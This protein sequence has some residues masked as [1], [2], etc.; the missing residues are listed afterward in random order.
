MSYLSI[1]DLPPPPQGKVGWPWTED[2]LKLAGRSLQ[3]EHWPRISI[4]TPNYNYTHFIEQTIRSILLQGYP[5]LEYI[6]VDDGSTDGS[7]EIIK[8]YEKWL[9][10][11]NTGPNRGQ[12]QAS[13]EGFKLASGEIVNWLCSD[14]FLLPQALL[15]VG[16][17]FYRYPKIDCLVGV[18]RTRYLNR[19]HKEWIFKPRPIHLIPVTV[20]F[21]QPSCFY[22]RE[23]LNRSPA[24]DE[25]YHYLMDLELWAYFQSKRINWKVIDNIL[26]VS[27]VHGQNKTSTGKYQVTY[28]LERIYKTYVTERIPLTFWHRLIRFPLE[29][30]SAKHPHPFWMVL[31][32]PIWIFWTMVLGLFY[33]WE[34]A[35]SMRWRWTLTRF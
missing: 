29:R 25:S 19:N 28:E 10:F 12:T 16:Q 5:H 26:S 23:L 6:I 22:R 11:W 1:Q 35:W 4:V 15:T 18:G 13:N 9:T 34:R 8:K 33:G 31:V 7:V 32:G 2:C 30:F 21:S 24:L 14:D 17:Y 20:P 27:L 3:R